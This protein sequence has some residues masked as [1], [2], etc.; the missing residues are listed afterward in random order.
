MLQSHAC[1]TA[2][3]EPIISKQARD[4]KR[5]REDKIRIRETQKWS[6]NSGKN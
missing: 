4:I 1:Q 2:K 3:L 6:D 5:M